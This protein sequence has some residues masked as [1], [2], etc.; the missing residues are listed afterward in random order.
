VVSRITDGSVRAVVVATRD[1][2]AVLKQALKK[3]KLSMVVLPDPFSKVSTRVGVSKLPR[4]LV[5]D[6]NGV[7]RK[8]FVN[9]GRKFE[10]DLAR[11]ID[12]VRASP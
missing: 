12:E 7:L 1:N 11:A 5:V 3:R 2:A 10:A 9:T 8:L 6:K 4:T